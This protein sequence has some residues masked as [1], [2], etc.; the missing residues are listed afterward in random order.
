MHSQAPQV[1]ITRLPRDVN[2]DVI[3]KHFRKFGKIREV[4][5]KR[6]YGFIVSLLSLSH[7]NAL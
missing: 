4:S 3:K 5:L 1:F 6:G 2:E 7:N